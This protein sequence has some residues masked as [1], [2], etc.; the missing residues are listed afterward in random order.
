MSDGLGALAIAAIPAPCVT[1]LIWAGVRRSRG[2]S[3]TPEYARRGVTFHGVWGMVLSLPL[4]FAG[5]AMSFGV[6]ADWSGQLLLAAT[7][8]CWAVAVLEILGRRVP[9]PLTW[10]PLVLVSVVLLALPS[11]SES[12]GQYFFWFAVYSLAGVGLAAW[13][14]VSVSFALSVRRVATGRDLVDKTA[15]IQSVPGF[16]WPMD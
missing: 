13:V 3:G 14:L 7:L 15:R 12:F 6:D 10:L 9:A 2:R 5:A 8:G 4:V 11:G 1:Y 16:V